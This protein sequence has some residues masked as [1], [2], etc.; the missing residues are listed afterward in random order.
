MDPNMT[1]MAT[2][3]GGRDLLDIVLIAWFILAGL[4]AAYVAG[5]AFANNPEL[6]VMKWGWILVT[7]YTGPVGAALYILS[8]KPPLPAEHADFVRPLWQ[9][10]LGSTI[11]SMKAATDSA[12]NSR[13]AIAENPACTKVSCTNRRSPR[14]KRS[15]PG[16]IAVAWVRSSA[17]GSAKNGFRTGVEQTIAGNRPPDGARD[18]S[19][20]ACRADRS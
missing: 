8:C 13:I 20:R 10:A 2:A 9:Q 11:Y 19:G 18:R 3:G 4:S 14:P 7:L 6:A 15:G 16:G 5:D 17:S 1:G 12:R